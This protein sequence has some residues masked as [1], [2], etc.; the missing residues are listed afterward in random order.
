MATRLSQVLMTAGRSL[1]VATCAFK[2]HHPVPGRL[3]IVALATIG[4]GLAAARAIAQVDVIQVQTVEELRGELSPGDNVTIVR[5]PESVVSGQLVRFGP[6]D[7][8]IR[9]KI[10][11]GPGQPG[12][13]ATLSI[14]HDTIRSLERTGDSTKNGMLIGAAVGGGFGLFNLIYY[15]IVD[16]NEIDEYSGSL[17]VGMAADAGIGAL[18]GY[19]IDKLHTRPPI[20]FEVASGEQ[21]GITPPPP[22]ARRP[23]PVFQGRE[24]ARFVVGGD[25]GWVHD[26]K[27]P[28]S[29]G[30]AIENTNVDIPTTGSTV[31]AGVFVKPDVSIWGEWTKLAPATVG[32]RG[33]GCAKGFPRARA[34]PHSPTG[35][36]RRSPTKRSLCTDSA[37]GCH[38][39]SRVSSDTAGPTGAASI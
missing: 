18:V 13:V 1:A 7:L 12:S 10:S 6:L 34:A 8:E 23:E 33:C 28:Q 32:Y 4:F 35:R 29:Y 25:F 37:P 36:V 39:P 20:R 19:F 16:A 26:S 5:S 11:Q 2:G 38:T 27:K 24:R 14:P 17:V 22:I 31:S 21:T 30:P 15:G 9:G 3:S